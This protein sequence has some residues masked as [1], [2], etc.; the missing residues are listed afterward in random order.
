MGL[1]TLTGGGAEG[2]DGGLRVRGEAE[3]GGAELLA[4]ERELEDLE[5]RVHLVR[6]RVS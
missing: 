4:V 5:H 3:G 1:V 6:V 2:K